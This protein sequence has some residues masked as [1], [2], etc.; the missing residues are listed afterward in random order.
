M[1]S[2]PLVAGV[3]GVK[4]DLQVCRHE[5]RHKGTHGDL[6]S[7]LRTCGW[8]RGWAARRGKRGVCDPEW[9]SAR[10]RVGLRE[11]VQLGRCVCVCV[12]V[13]CGWQGRTLSIGCV[14]G[15]A[16]VWEAVCSYGMCDK[17]SVIACES[18]ECVSVRCDRE[19]QGASGHF[20]GGSA[21]KES[22]CQCRR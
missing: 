9:P 7:G 3:G 18:N 12:C 10:E 21:D 4:G 2:E 15:E 11:S 5:L 19:G 22:T 16:Q 14:K 17:V 20:P 6:D 13:P 8:V 1:G